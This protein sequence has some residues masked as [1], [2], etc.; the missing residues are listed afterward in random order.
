MEQKIPKKIHYVWVG[1]AAKPEAMLE[2][3]ASWEKYCPD[4]EI[5]EWNESNFDL[6]RYPVVKKALAQRNW[7]FVSDVIRL[8]AI[9]NY[10]GIYFDTDVEVVRPL[11]GLLV[12]DAFLAYE[13]KYWFASAT[14]GGAR[15]H[16]FFK[17]CLARYETESEINFSANPLAVHNLSATAK[18]LYG[19][20]TNGKTAVLDNNIA[21]LAVDYFSPLDY[22]SKRLKITD[23]TYAVH[24]FATTWHSKSQK[25]WAGFA[26]RCRRIMGIHIYRIFERIVAKN[27][28]R[29]LSREYNNRTRAERGIS[30]AYS[31]EIAAT[32]DTD[33]ER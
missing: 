31:P 32:K 9:Y 18:R 7:A 28:V 23:N 2:C 11:D 25:F 33:A 6:D 17:E 4:Y 13:S 16:E 3:I 15:G 21:L 27:Y 14:C 29:T 10:G 20:K 22:M 19:I 8:W 12:Y 1:G 30:G 24:R 5:I 26:K